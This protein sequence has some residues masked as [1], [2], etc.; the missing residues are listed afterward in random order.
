MNACASCAI[1]GV[2]VLPVPIAQTGSYAMTRLSSAL[3]QRDLALQN[4][5]R[6]RLA[7]APPRSRRRTRSRSMPAPSAARAP[8]AHG[9]VGLAEVLP[10]LRVAD[11]RA[12]HAE[13]EQHAAP[14]SRRCTH[15][16][17]PS[18]RSARQPRL[19]VPAR[20]CTA[21]A[22]RHVRRADDDVDAGRDPA[23][24][25]R[26][27]N[28]AASAG[29]LVH[30]PVACDQRQ[31]RQILRRCRNH[32]DAGK[33]LPFEELQTPRRHPSRATRPCRRARARSAPEPSRRR[34]RP[35]RRPEALPPPPPPSSLRRSGG[36][37]KTPI[38]PF[39]KIVRAFAMRPRE[40]LT[41]LRAD[42]ETASQPSGSAS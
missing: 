16:P 36:H 15:P 40:Q 6:S 30:L 7:R 19:S 9:L 13:L 39:Q 10:P 8:V 18:A 17:A 33:V 12:V 14:R 5:P 37:S 26:R 35:N 23:S 24:R 2:A 38:G 21:T 3:E 34:R 4:A 28:S 41:R 27:Q 29:A 20:S 25:R 11:D 22:R 42:V 31:G 32:A 1:S